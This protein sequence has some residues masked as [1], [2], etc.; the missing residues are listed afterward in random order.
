MS[1]HWLIACRCVNLISGSCS[2]LVSSEFDK[3]R[4][5]VKSENLLRS[6]IAHPTRSNLLSSGKK[7]YYTGFLMRTP[8]LKNVFFKIVLHIKNPV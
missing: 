3:H 5:K 1:L 2:L 8:I 7:R 4:K 6:L